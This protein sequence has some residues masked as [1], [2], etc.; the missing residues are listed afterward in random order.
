MKDKVVI[1]TGGSSGIGYSCAAYFCEKG[2]KVVITGRNE[3]KLKDATQSLTSIGGEIKGIVSD[4][5]KEAEVVSLIETVINKWGRIDVLI[6]NAGISMRS[7]FE[8]VDL[9]VFKQVMDINFYGTLYITKHALPHLKHSKGSIIG[10]SS[11][12]G[13]KGLPARTAYSASKFAMEGFLQSLRIELL[14][15]NVHVLVVSPGF[16]KTGIREAALTSEGDSQGASPKDESKLMTPEQVAEAVYDAT[17][18]RKRDLVLTTQ[19]KMLVKVN[20]FA[21]S[22]ADNQVYKHFANEKDSPLKK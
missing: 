6:N 4:V 5:S 9:E 20:K 7:M 11:I 8:D 1:I 14:K 13:K 22:F 15:D 18:K 10:V 2:S 21:P 19:G 16:V 3:D 17:I 12:A